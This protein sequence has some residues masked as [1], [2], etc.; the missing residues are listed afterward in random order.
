MVDGPNTNL[1]G[2]SVHELIVC[3]VR[4]RFYYISVQFSS[5]AQSCLTLC[6]PMDCSTPG[7]PVHHQLPE[8]TQTHVH[9]VGDCITD[10]P[11][12]SLNHLTLFRP[13]LLPPSIFPSI[14][15]FSIESALC[16]RWS[17]YWS[18][19]FSISPTYVCVINMML[20]IKWLTN[21]I[22]NYCSK[23]KKKGRT[24][25]QVWNFVCLKTRREFFPRREF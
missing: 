9:W 24:D 3:N 2:T 14:R 15:V 18:F 11:S 12:P 1:E 22:L 19:S 4:L 21:H 16:I 23:G 6:Y 7:L 17:E 10:S 20:D 8:F 13:L 5:V 25:L